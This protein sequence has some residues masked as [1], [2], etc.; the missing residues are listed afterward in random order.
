MRRKHDSSDG[1]SGKMEII[2]VKKLGHI[3]IIIYV[4]CVSKYIYIIHVCTDRNKKN[5]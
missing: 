5:S 1:G 3:D 4:S 2:T